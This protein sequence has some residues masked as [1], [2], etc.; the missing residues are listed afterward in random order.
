M[1]YKAKLGHT[2]IGDTMI[3]P[4]CGSAMVKNGK[5]TLKMRGVVQN[6]C[7]GVVGSVLAAIGRE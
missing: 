4:K 2:C 1:I 5:R 3:C 7:A 6:F